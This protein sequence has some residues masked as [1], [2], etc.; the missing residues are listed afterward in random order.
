VFRRRYI[1]GVIH[2][3]QRMA[4]KT[5][6]NNVARLLWMRAAC[7][8]AAYRTR[9]SVGGVDDPCQIRPN[10][11][12]RVQSD[13][14]RLSRVVAGRMLRVLQRAL[15]SVHAMRGGVNDA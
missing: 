14:I 6:S 2:H 3:V 13:A 7:A 12:C 8:D 15:R 1:A 9:V 4:F 11:H 5:T 10:N